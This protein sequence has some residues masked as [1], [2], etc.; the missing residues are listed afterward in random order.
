M[1]PSPPP[2]RW[3]ARPAS[4]WPPQARGPGRGW[5]APAPNQLASFGCVEKFGCVENRPGTPQAR[6]RLRVRPA[7]TGA[8]PSWSVF[9]CVAS[10]PPSTGESRRP[11]HT[12]LS[13]PAHASAR[14]PR[15]SLHRQL[16]GALGGLAAAPQ[17]WLAGS[18]RPSGR[19]GSRV[20]RRAPRPTPPA[21]GEGTPARSHRRASRL[22]RGVT[23]GLPTSHVPAASGPPPRSVDP[24][25][26]CR[27]PGG[28]SP[29]YIPSDPI[30]V[31][32][33][34]ASL[35]VSRKFSWGCP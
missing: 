34:G 18:H 3:P 17:D 27:R 22:A 19:R 30:W 7:R 15:P 10:P 4:P 2:P 26:G 32:K 14:P 5:A 25:A 23:S 9:G 6:R 24:P 13:P 8:R 21:R 31:G 16:A 1:P 33:W 28:F 11:R 35:K 12:T 29:H 20:A